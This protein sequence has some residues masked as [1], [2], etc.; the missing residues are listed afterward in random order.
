MS[1]IRRSVLAATALLIMTALMASSAHAGRKSVTQMIYFFSPSCDHCMRVKA[2]VMPLV[3]KHYSDVVEVVYKD[4]TD[5]ENYKELFELKHKYSDDEKTVFPVMF[6]KGHFIDQRDIAAKGDKVIFSFIREAT[7]SEAAEKKNT[8]KT[9]I[10]AYF[11]KIKPLAVLSAGFIDGINPC[12]FTVIVFFL[13][14][15][16]VQQ[17]NHKTIV[18]AGSAFI[19]ACF[20]TYVAIGLGLLAPLYA[21]KA[22]RPITQGVS[23]VIG[24]FSMLLGA[25]ALYD[26][27]MFLRTKNP[28]HSL[29]QLP[30]KIKDRIHKLVGSEYRVTKEGREAQMSKSIPKIFLSALAIGFSVSIL[31]SVCTGQLYLPT[32]IFVLKTSPYKLQALAYLLAY[33]VMFILPICG[34]FVLALAGMTS[35]AFASVLKRYFFAIKIVMAV[36]FLLL[37]ASL[38]WAE[39]NASS[40]APTKVEYAKDPNFFDFGKV[41]EGDVLKHIFKFKN[42][43]PAAIHIKEVNT[44]CSCTS[45]K[46]DT[47]TIEPGQEIPIE[48]IFETKGFTGLRK[49]QLFVHTDSR[50]NPLVI[51]E[52]QAD[53]Q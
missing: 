5:V 11:K 16:A 38:V 21:F 3:E 28:E 36:L 2:V 46:I 40:N 52:V 9:D 17:Y 32:I 51:F 13:S 15:L 48:I 42:N 27:F 18:W 6:I 10:F 49:R 14:F 41:T 53:I 44:S 34:I 7:A 31:E 45:S 47:K 29:L 20:I 43:E 39:D 26:A 22:F 4:I 50:T 33:N 8:L 1:H 37:G 19:L 35:Q 25:A 24:L 30:K 23:V 12:S